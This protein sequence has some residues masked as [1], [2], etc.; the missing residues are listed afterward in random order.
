MSLN[1]SIGD[2]YPHLSHDEE[3]RLVKFREALRDVISEECAERSLFAAAGRKIRALGTDL[4]ARLIGDNKKGLRNRLT[5]NETQHEVQL[6]QFAILLMRKMDTLPLEELCRLA[7]GVYVRVPEVHEHDDI[8]RELM[9]CIKEFGDIGNVLAD[10]MSKDSDGGSDITRREMP[11][12]RRE[13][14]EAVAKIYE[15]LAAVEEQVK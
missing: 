8:Q 14:E 10:A 6:I 4:A 7:N 12:I 13:F 5:P 9:A 1:I 11:H 3:Q 15:L 2:K